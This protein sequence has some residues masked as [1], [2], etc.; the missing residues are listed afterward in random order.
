MKRIIAVG[1]PHG[2]GKSSVAKRLAKELS[3]TYISAGGVFRQIAK[4]RGISMK[5]MSEKVLEEPDIDIQIDDRTKKLG[6]EENTIVD[7]QLAAH[8]TPKDAILKICIDASFEVR[9]ERI[10]SRENMSI[11]QSH[12]ETKTREKSERK[13]FLDLY[14]IDI[15]DLSV[16]DVVINNNRL[17]EEETYQLT[18]GIVLNIFEIK[19]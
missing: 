14:G 19:K 7:A 10:A 11:D 1:G 5:E 17:N 12:L 15:D 9:C 2:S 16:F 6:S 4:E 8:F 18:K 13:R 3:M